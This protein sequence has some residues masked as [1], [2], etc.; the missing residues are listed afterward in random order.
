MDDVIV[1]DYTNVGVEVNGA[2]NI[3][4]GVHTWNG[5]GRGIVVNSYQTRLIG[6]YLDYD[7][8]VLVDPT[9]IVVDST[10]FLGTNTIFQAKRGQVTGVLMRFNSYTG[11]SSISLQGTFTSVASVSIAEEINGNKFTRTRAVLTQKQATVWKFDF[12]SVL[13]F[14]DI[15][16]ATYSLASADGASVAHWMLPPQGRV[17]EIHTAEA[18]DATVSIEVAQAL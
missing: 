7:S 10:F 8:L 15:E 1:F 4:S 9:Q 14:P 6:C 2:A 11:G 18:I 5:G 3:L 12:S 16:Y 13:L 17:V